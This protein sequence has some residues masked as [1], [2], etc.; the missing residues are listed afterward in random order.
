MFEL[1]GVE[2][3]EVVANCDHL[4]T[5]RYSGALPCAFTE[6]RSRVK[7]VEAVAG[8]MARLAPG[9]VCRAGRGQFSH[10]LGENS[11]ASW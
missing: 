1:T 9:Q 11:L 3:A 7:G 5:L 4:F 6:V 8:G 2:E 10:G